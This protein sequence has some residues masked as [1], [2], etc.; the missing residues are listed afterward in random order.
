M[1]LADILLLVK[2]GYSRE[3]ITAMDTQTTATSNPEPIPA[4]VDVPVQDTKPAEQTAQVVEPVATPTPA[5]QTVPQPTPE[6]PSM[7]DIMQSIA[8]LT[9]AVQA[10]AIASSVIPQGLSIPPKA[11][12]MI[13][14]IIRPTFQERR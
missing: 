5:P 9:S 4:T 14:E 11:E 10:N 13:A 2:A 1:E 6:Q 12:D 3:E 8:K 7:A